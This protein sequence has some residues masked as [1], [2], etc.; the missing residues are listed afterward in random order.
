MMKF[1]IATLLVLKTAFAAGLGDG[2]MAPADVMQVQDL[3]GR[4]L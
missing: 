2:A 1:T 3:I 4:N